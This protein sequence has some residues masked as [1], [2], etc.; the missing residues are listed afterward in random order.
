MVIDLSAYQSVWAAFAAQAASSPGRCA[1]AHHRGDAPDTADQVTY[2]E[3]DRRIQIRAA[4][5]GSRFTAGERVLIALPSDLEFVEVYLACLAAGLVA[6]PAPP[7]GG[8]SRAVERIA[9]IAAD[10]APALAVAAGPDRAALAGELRGLGDRDI[11]VEEPGRVGASEVPRA[12]LIA[13]PD[14]DMLAVLQYSS[15]STGVPR[16]VMLTHGDILENLAVL[17]RDMRI[18]P[19]DWFGSWLPLH[20]DMGLFGHLSVGLLAGAGVVL[21]PATSFL[22]RPAGWFRMLSDYGITFTGAPDFAY[23]MCCRLIPDQAVDGL[24]LSRVRIMLNGSEPINAET[25]ARF[26]SRFGWTGLRPEALTPAY[27]LAESTVYVTCKVP[28]SLAKVVTADPDRLASPSRP[29]VRPANGPGRKLMGHGPFARGRGCIVDPETRRVL[30]DGEIGELWLRG[31]GIGRGY[32]N[33]AELSEQTFAASLAGHDAGADWLRT[34][35]LGTFIDGELFIT[36]RSKETMIVHGRKLYPQ[37]LEHEARVAHQALSGFFGAA[38]GVAVPDERVVLVHEINPAVSADELAGVAGVVSRQLTSALGI[39]MRNVLLVRRGTVPRT[40]SGKIQRGTTR[41][42]FLA[43]EIV[44]LYAD[45][46]P[47]VLAAIGG[48]GA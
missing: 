35:D 34:G 43:G 21:M 22:R 12:S 3:L 31:P 23:D 16:G 40:T 30:P 29:Q 11:P 2:S 28:G 33:R 15:G 37:D 13:L 47:A 18:G 44:P 27:G 36:G 20:H 10:C 4:D 14:R 9:G 39:P 26:A 19:E 17:M 24:D 25:M 6:V 48:T 38:F 5:L 41:A 42:R 8:S 1:I 7:P 32:W 45:L 46:E